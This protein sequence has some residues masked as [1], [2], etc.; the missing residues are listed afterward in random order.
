MSPLPQTLHP[1]YHLL[2]RNAYQKLNSF[3]SRIVY[4]HKP[5]NVN[6][7]LKVFCD[8]SPNG[9]G[10]CFIHVMPNGDERPVAYV[11]CSLSYAEQN[12]THIEHEK[13]AIV[14]VVR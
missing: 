12:Y 8:A 3:C 10:A 6:K 9:P 5:L 4:W 11:S 7:P 13:L 14:F 2:R 1:L